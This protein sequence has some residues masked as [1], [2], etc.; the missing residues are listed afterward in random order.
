MEVNCYSQWAH[1]VRCELCCRTNMSC[2]CSFLACLFNILCVIFPCVEPSPSW[3]ATSCVVLPY[4]AGSVPQHS[5]LTSVEVFRKTPYIPQYLPLYLF[6]PSSPPPYNCKESKTNFFNKDEE[7]DINRVYI[8]I[9]S[10]VW[11]RERT[12]PTEWP[13]L[14][15][16]V[17]ANLC[18]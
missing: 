11:V 16:E 1:A 10:M 18:G 5:H 9:N 4:P 17:I 3:E 12:I 14:V 2:S 8:Y 15:G 7:G 6:S 13:P